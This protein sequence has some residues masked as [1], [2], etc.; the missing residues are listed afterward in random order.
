MHVS[1]SLSFLNNL[2]KKDP[3]AK[4]MEDVKLNAL[5]ND[6]VNVFE[7]DVGDSTFSYA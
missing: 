5:T 6:N 1:K 4:W 2:P 3:L 7:L